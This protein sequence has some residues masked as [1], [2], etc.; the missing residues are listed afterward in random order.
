MIKA[1]KYYSYNQKQLPVGCQYCVRG[2]KVVLFVTG[3]CPRKCYFCP[4]S[5][6]KYGNDVQF[7]NERKIEDFTQLIQEAQA[8]DAK[9]AGIT[10]G[11]PL[12]KT[13]RVCEYIQELKKKFG[14]KFHCHLYT[15]LNLVTKETLRKLHKA[16]LDEIRFHLDLDDKKFWDRIS[17]ANEFDW[18]V[19]V[20][21]P[22]MPNKEKETKE[23][24]DFI[25]DKVKFINLN[26]LERSDNTLSTL[27]QQG[28]KTKSTYSYAIEGSLAAGFNLMKYS[29][30]KDYDLAIHLCTAK[31]KD[32]IQLTN[33]IK[34]EGENSKK[35]FDE[36]DEEGLLHR[37]AL[38]LPELTPGFGYRERLE[39]INKEEY[40]A[41]LEQ[42]FAEIKQKFRLTEQ[43][44]FLDKQKVRI[45]LSSKKARKNKKY[46]KKLKLK[47]AIVTEYPTADQLE[48]EIDFI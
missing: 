23:I 12:M 18:D 19:G 17:L 13:D 3:L 48:I 38:Y 47:I 42:K 1:N 14:K 6:E 4:V 9:G 25:H 5:D 33:R 2:E 24:I 10:G 26:E 43:E 35:E 29:K 32:G 41:K 28:M 34:R 27:T 44:V 11:D 31:L 36:M 20:E 37:G 21:L 7:A 40:L 30:E 39:K 8:M 22:L 16:G 46:F 15:S 45:L